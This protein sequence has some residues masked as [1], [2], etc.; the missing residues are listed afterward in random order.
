M[1]RFEVY[2]LILSLAAIVIIPLIVL[3][4]RIT[5]KWTRVEGKLETLA[6][7]MDKLVKDKDAIHTEMISQMRDDRKAT[8]RRLRWLEE[9][10]WKGSS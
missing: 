9:H 4:V 5:Q 3:L 8:D 10:L 1:T 2:T 6:N 7:N